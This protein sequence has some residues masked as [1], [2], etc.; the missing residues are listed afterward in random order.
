MGSFGNVLIARLPTNESIGGRS[1]CP[2]CGRVIRVRELIP[3]ISFLMLE[4]K[5]AGCQKPISW[6]YPLVEITS[7]LLFCLGFLLFRNDVVSAVCAAF[8]LWALLLIAAIDAKTQSIPDVLT[9]IVA[10]AGAI[11]H[12]R[13]G[14]IGIIA[15][16][17]G[18]AFFGAQ[19]L[20]SRG[21]WVGSGDILLAV[22]MGLFLGAWP[23][24]FV[25]LMLAY[26][27]GACFVTVQL[28]RQK[29]K[30]GESVAFG[31]FLVVGTVI[32]F[33][34]GEKILDALLLI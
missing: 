17:I 25:A 6:Q 10:V 26:V 33:V 24:M 27:I 4:G 23:V 8:G 12:W 20:F 9:L 30:A 5:C 19:W 21:T 11:L 14:D 18:A 34:Y 32:A 1:H 29:T 2:K 3:V 31:P 15:P 28:M 22:A 7:A 13:L 16:L